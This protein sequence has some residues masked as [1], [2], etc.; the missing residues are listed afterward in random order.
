MF[1]Q[2]NHVHAIATAFGTM[3]GFQSQPEWFKSAAESP[4]WQVI[5]AAVLVYQG[6]G[7]LDPMYSL[8]I[9]ILFYMFVEATKYINFAKGSAV[10]SEDATVAEDAAPEYYSNYY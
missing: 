5:C 7:A 8:V 1:D 3:G 2:H 6:G 10:G 4:V 9:A